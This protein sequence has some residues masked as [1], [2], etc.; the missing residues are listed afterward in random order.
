LLCEAFLRNPT[1]NAVED[2]STEHAQVVGKMF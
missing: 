2:N 1:G